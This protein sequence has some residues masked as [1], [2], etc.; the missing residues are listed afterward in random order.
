MKFITFRRY[1]LD[2]LLAETDFE[3]KVLDV[4]GTRVNKRGNFRP[5]VEKVQKWEYLNIDEK[6]CPDYLCASDKIPVD[7]ET[8][9]MIVITEVL[10]HLERPQDTLKEAFRVLK[11][12]GRLIAS[13]PFL[14]PVHP[15]PF[16][17]QRWTQEKIRLEFD[18]AGF[19]EIQIRTM[20]GFFAVVYDLMHSFLVEE[21]GKLFF[22]R[23][24]IYKIL[25]PLSAVIY[26][27]LD[28]YF[29]TIHN[30]ITTGFYVTAVK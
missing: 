8:F 28:N 17:F 18:K 15:D 22:I 29:A 9:D 12:Q 23:K 5:P 16:D 21:D 13:V 4:G 10:E 25:M 2:R 24:V 14:Y 19:K 1:W 20:G 30:K 7:D 26:R 11:K 6:T 27:G 3:G